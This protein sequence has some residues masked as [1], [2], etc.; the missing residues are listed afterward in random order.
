MIGGILLCFFAFYNRFPLVFW[1]TGTYMEMAFGKEVRMERPIFYGLFIKYISMKES[2]GLV[3]YAQAIALASTLYLAIKHFTKN[4]AK[5]NSLFLIYISIIVLFTGASFHTSRLMPDTFTPVFLLS[6]AMLF[7]VKKLSLFE[8]IYLSIVLVVSTIFH[9]THSIMFLIFMFI[10]AVIFAVNRIKKN[11]I[12]IPQRLF[13]LLGLY[14][15]SYSAPYF[16]SLAFRG[17]FESYKGSHV[18]MLNRLISTNILPQYLEKNCDEEKYSLCKYKDQINTSFMWDRANSPLYKDGGWE[19]TKDRYNAIIKDILSNPY[20]LK[21]YIAMSTEYAF[22]QFFY[23]D[24]PMNER[25]KKGTLP[26]NAIERYFNN[27]I[28]LFHH[29]LQNQD[30]LHLVE[31]INTSQRFLVFFSLLFIVILL[32]N[33]KKFT[34]LN[35]ENQYLFIFILSSL[36]LNAILA[37][38]FSEVRFRYQGRIIW[39]ATLPVFI[40]FVNNYKNYIESLKHLFATKKK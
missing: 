27:Y 31:K 39:L 9:N 38:F 25:F 30:R 15:V 33:H 3:I 32:A 28:S 19:D 10:V 14:L 24:I 2:L 34:A 8:K 13:L 36:V 7:I 26:Y 35:I 22:S 29:S 1:D 18:F 40:Y 4:K 12:F 20:Y 11:R 17:K 6:F 23:F 5:K 37:G 21:K 16:S